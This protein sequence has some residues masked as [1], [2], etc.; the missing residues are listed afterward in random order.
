MSSYDFSR[1]L[2]K[3]YIKVVMDFTLGEYD[4][5]CKKD[6]APNDVSLER[7]ENY[8]EEKNHCPCGSSKHDDIW[9]S[10]MW[11]QEPKKC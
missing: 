11:K 10:R 5:H 3:F 1:L 2:L 6:T 8:Y 7:N 9:A 4:C